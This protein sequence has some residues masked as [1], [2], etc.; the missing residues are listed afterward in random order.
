MQAMHVHGHRV[1]IMHKLKS[2][3][4]H[5]DVSI[6]CP[7]M[8]DNGWSFATT[9]AD[10]TGDMANGKKYLYEVYQQ[11]QPNLSTRVTVPV[12]CGINKNKPSSTTN[13]HKS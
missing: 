8:L 12:L 6:V 5:I 7:D 3:Q 1:L 2:L 13:P 4:K 11:A 10:T 9:H